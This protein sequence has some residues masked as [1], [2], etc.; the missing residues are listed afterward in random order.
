M[1]GVKNVS[2]RVHEAF[3]QKID[4]TGLTEVK[5]NEARTTVCGWLHSGG[6]NILRLIRLD[7]GGFEFIDAQ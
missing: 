4:R 7:N 6:N 5:V 2:G 3:M 1:T